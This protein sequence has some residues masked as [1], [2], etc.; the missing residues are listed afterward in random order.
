MARTD[1]L[2]PAAAH[3]LH[4][5]VNASTWAWEPVRRR[6]ALW[7]AASTV[8]HAWTVAELLVPKRGEHSVGVHRV[9]DPATGRAVN[10]Q[11]AVG[12][13]LVTDAHCHP[14]DWSL[15]LDGVWD[16]DR[17]RRLRARIPA[18][19]TAR[20]AGAHVVGH[21]AGVTAH[22]LMPR[23]PWALDLTRG[24]DAGE[25]LAGL[26]R[27]TADLVCEVDPGQVVVSGH[28]APTVTTVGGLFDQRRARRP[29]VV[30]RDMADGRHRAVTVH[31]YADTVRLPRRQGGGEASGAHRFRLLEVVDPASRQP[32]RYWLTGP[33]GRSAE[34]VLLAMRGRAG[35]QAAL[36][37][38]R[39]RFGV[40]DFEGRSFPGWHHHMT[41]ASAAYVY[42]HLRGG[43]EAAPARAAG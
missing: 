41:M 9:T 22:P 15:V 39:E 3:G 13:F 10:A 27:H 38:L 28:H 32:A 23:L 6:L 2:P 8:P 36:A 18:D 29:Y 42:H 31:T 35:L 34:K 37:A 43:P 25:V 4:Q 1:G 11:R 16:R 26:V 33:G 30:T 19:E 20:T 7:V 14:V 40:L 5:F 24:H 12:L 21:V 17:D